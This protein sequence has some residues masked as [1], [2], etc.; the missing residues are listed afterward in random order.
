MHARR[1]ENKKHI[2][3]LTWDPPFTYHS[4]WP[5]RRKQFPVSFFCRKF[6]PCICLRGKQTDTPWKTLT[7][8]SKI[9]ASTPDIPLLQGKSFANPKNEPSTVALQAPC[10]CDQGTSPN[11]LPVLPPSRA[12][13]HGF[14]WWLLHPFIKAWDEHVDCPLVI[15]RMILQ[16]RNVY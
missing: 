4:K 12:C 10:A 13:S 1:I 5:R 6:K 15:S 7:F 14:A 16:V 11:K 8:S 3:E 9:G 2:P